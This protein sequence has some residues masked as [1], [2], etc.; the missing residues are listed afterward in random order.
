M[1][2]LLNG[3]TYGSDE[4]NALASSDEFYYG[5][6]S[7]H[8]VGSSELRNIFG[9]PDRQ[10]QYLKGKKSNTDALTIGKLTHQCW[11]EPDKFYENVFVETERVDSKVYK[12]ALT[13]H[14]PDIVYKMKYKTMSEWLCRKLDTNEHIAK[15]RKGADVEVPMVRM[16][17]INGRQV[18]VRGKADLI[19]DDIIY[20]LKTTI[21]SPQQFEWKIDDVDYDLQAYIYMQLF[22]RCKE[23]HF[24]CINKH[25]RSVGD[26]LVKPEHIER[27]KVKFNLALRA[28]FEIFYE[29]DLDE[30]QYKLDQHIYIGESR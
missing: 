7:K 28:Y 11:L 10:L 18:P 30:I 1:I 17:E 19:K 16:F 20:D 5:Q 14:D 23:F 21:V 8:A 6:L 27:G 12:E 3:D 25:N 2:T 4:I 29:R 26:I 22:P 9:D 24:I 13:K 15:I